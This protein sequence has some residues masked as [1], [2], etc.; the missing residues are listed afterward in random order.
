MSTRVT[1]MDT[2][3]IS[4]IK[5]VHERTRRLEFP[6]GHDKRPPAPYDPYDWHNDCDRHPP[7][8]DDNH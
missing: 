5:V 7:D 1:N 6:N 3:L 8:I 4:S 2:H